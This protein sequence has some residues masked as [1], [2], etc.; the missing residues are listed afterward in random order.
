MIWVGI[1]F[2][3]LLILGLHALNR[4][5]GPIRRTTFSAPVAMATHRACDFPTVGVQFHR[6]EIE[7]L[8]GWT[9][10]NE[11]RD[12]VVLRPEPK[13]RTERKPS[14]SKCADAKSHMSPKIGQLNITNIWM[15]LIFAGAPRLA[16]IEF[17]G[18]FQWTTT[19][20]IMANG[21]T[22]S[23]RA[24]YGRWQSQFLVSRNTFCTSRG[25]EGD[26]R[27][28]TDRSTQR[29]GIRTHGE[30]ALRS[31]APHGRMLTLSG[32]CR[33]RARVPC[34]HDCAGSNSVVHRR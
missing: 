9:D 10:H 15:P 19:P 16:K 8:V 32:E 22:V 27:S 14:P 18:G 1:A 34:L 24:S 31:G 6:H 17:R 20:T 5:S 2:I 28:A 13:T 23:A 7:A 29:H 33:P 25:T 3:V 21:D 12:E 30:R 11:I 4:S 26:G